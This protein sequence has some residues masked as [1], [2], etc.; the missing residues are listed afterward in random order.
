MRG[1]L[2]TKFGIRQ[3]FSDLHRINLKTKEI[4]V[5]PD[6]AKVPSH[7]SHFA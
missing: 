4:H 5:H 3:Y 2:K 1:F 6:L 7:Y